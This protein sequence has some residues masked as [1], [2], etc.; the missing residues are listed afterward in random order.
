MP[1]CTAE[2][3]ALKNKDKKA[4]QKAFTAFLKCKQGKQEK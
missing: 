3:A 2:R 4:R 1:D